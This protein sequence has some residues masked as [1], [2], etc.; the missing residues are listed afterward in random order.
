M[1]KFSDDLTINVPVDEFVFQCSES[2]IDELIELLYEEYEEKFTSPP[3]NPT[4]P[5]QN[6]FDT[7]LGNISKNYYLLSNEEIEFIEKLSR[8][9]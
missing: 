4:S 6:S 8:K 2:E 7:M 5:L 9:Y 1:P 3:N